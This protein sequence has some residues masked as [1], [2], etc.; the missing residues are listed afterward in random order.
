M[1]CTA[2]SVGY[3]PVAGAESKRLVF[4]ARDGYADL[5]VRIPC[6]KCN[7]CICDKAR[8]WAVRCVHE[9]AMHPCNTFATFTYA[10]MPPRASLSLRTFQLF[11]KKLR[12]TYGPVRFLAS[13]E[14][15][16]RF[17]RP[18]YHAL[19]FGLDFPD[20][21]P[22]A[23]SAGGHLLYRSP[24]LEKLWGLG[25]VDLGPVNLQTAGYV[26]RYSTEKIEAANTPGYYS[27]TDPETGEAWEVAREFVTMSRR[28]GLGFSWFQQFGGEL[29]PGDFAIV[30]GQKY[31]VPDYY[32]NL[33]PEAD[34]D[35]IRS[36]RHQRGAARGRA[37]E[38]AH[39]ASGYGQARL[40][41]KHQ[42]GEMRAA[43]LIRAGGEA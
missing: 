26:A 42:L 18:H 16:G 33:L 22:S 20:K 41:T 9:A 30:D 6:N 13:G 4:N 37:E 25:R 17:G 7:G 35:R 2:P 24:E 3:R 31:P 27:R 28:P 8:D 29:F 1:P 14:Y 5:P 38:A 12:F 32:L 34:Q 36:R 15:G 23:R 21:A 43:R 39:A 10:E 11:M 40:L 19:L